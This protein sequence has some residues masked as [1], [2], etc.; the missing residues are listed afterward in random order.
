MPEKTKSSILLTSLSPAVNYPSQQLLRHFLV[1]ALRSYYLG[2][3]LGESSFTGLSLR[4]QNPRRYSAMGVLLSVSQFQQDGRKL[5][6]RG[7]RLS[8]L[9]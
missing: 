9:S 8:V 4:K 7:I 1:L 5:S 3:H 2:Q 6:I